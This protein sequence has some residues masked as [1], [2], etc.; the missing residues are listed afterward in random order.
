M[1]SRERLL[2]AYNNEKP[3]HLPATVHSWMEY[4][5]DTY[6]GGVDQYEAYEATGLDMVIY[7]VVYE[8][9]GGMFL[10]ISEMMQTPDWKVDQ[11]TYKKEEGVAATE[12]AIT[13]PEKIITAKTET[14]VYTT[15]ITEP[16]VKEKEDIEILKKYMPYP[17]IDVKAVNSIADG[18]GDRGILRTHV[19]GY[20]QPGCW[21]DACCLYGT[22]NMIYAAYDDPGWVHSFLKILM[23]KKLEWLD[24]MKGA[25]FDV[26]ELGGGDA[27]DTVISPDMFAEF[28][29]PYDKKIVDAIHSIDLR[30]VYHTCGGM[31]NILDQIKAT[32][33]DGSETLTPQGMGGNADLEEIKNK[34][35]EIMFL[36][37]GFDQLHG[38]KDCST[39]VTRSMVF[40]C[41]E[42]AG[43]D[44]GY[45]ICPSDHFFDADVA[46]VRA[47]AEAAKECRY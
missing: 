26:L 7:D 42:K 37:G 12:Y 9:K 39:D 4:F 34:F 38:F 5:L 14:N 3:D 33:A 22:T 16:P 2:A 43:P 40:D 1:T 8:D 18:I 6:L 35:G 47:F 46:N 45:V 10:Y 27:S 19:F 44:G 20:G 15:W 32:G 17:R 23:V 29:L 24:A 21:Q 36:Q 31:M 11:N 41:F 13:T 25:R 30:V 28:V